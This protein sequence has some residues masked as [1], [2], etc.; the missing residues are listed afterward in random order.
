MPTPL[1]SD[2]SLLPGGPRVP[3]GPGAAW[4]VSQTLEKWKVTLEPSSFLLLCI[5]VVLFLLT[6]AA[7]VALLASLAL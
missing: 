1:R 2:T 7:L 5:L 4:R 3:G 6:L